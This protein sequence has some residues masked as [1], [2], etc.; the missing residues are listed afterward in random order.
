M[1][2]SRLSAQARVAAALSDS[3]PSYGD[4]SGSSH[5]QWLGNLEWWQPRRCLVPSPSS[6][7]RVPVARRSRRRPHGMAASAPAATSSPA[8][9]CTLKR[10][11][12]RKG[13][14]RMM[15]H[16]LLPNITRSGKCPLPMRLSSELHRASSYNTDHAP[17]SYVTTYDFATA[18]SHVYK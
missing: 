4:A 15:L 13:L 1:A 18:L 9:P 2:S 10:L 16:A 5:K 12:R 11:C 7:A 8:H 17:S 6:H 14:G 3:T